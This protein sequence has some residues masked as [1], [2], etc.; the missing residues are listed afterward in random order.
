MAESIFL[1]FNLPDPESVNALIEE[2]FGTED[3]NGIQLAEDLIVELVET[4]HNRTFPLNDRRNRAL[5]GSILDLSDAP[6]ERVRCFPESAEPLV[7]QKLQDLVKRYRKLVNETLLTKD[8]GPL[9]DEFRDERITECW[10]TERQ[11]RI[12]LDAFDEVQRVI[13]GEI[14]SKQMFEDLPFEAPQ[15]FREDFEEW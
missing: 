13:S 10:S 7:F 8:F 12:G 15:F 2:V 5:I 1:T 6:F 3:A 9:L 11:K 14:T 4:I